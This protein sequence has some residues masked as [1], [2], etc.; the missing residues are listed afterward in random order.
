MA[1]IDEI[2]ERAARDVRVDVRSVVNVDA[3]LESILGGPAA[4]SNF[5]MAG[6]LTEMV[7]VGNLSVRTGER[8]EWD[9]EKMKVLNHHEAQKY[10]KRERRKGWEL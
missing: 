7:L 5:D 1:S 8:I 10:V 2:A 3:G 9:A 4:A 6:P